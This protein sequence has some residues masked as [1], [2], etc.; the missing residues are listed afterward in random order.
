[1]TDLTLPRRSP[2]LKTKWF[3]DECDLV[4]QSGPCTW[5]APQAPDADYVSQTPEVEWVGG[6]GALGAVFVT[7][8][9]KVGGVTPT[10]IPV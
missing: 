4:R 8:V 6:V 2:T 1:M 3:Q 5:R 10:G 7:E 9:R